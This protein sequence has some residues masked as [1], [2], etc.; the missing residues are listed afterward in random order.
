MPEIELPFFLNNIAPQRSLNLYLRSIEETTRYNR[1]RDYSVHEPAGTS[2]PACPVVRLAG[3]GD[4][5]VIA[6][7]QGLTVRPPEMDTALVAVR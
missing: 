4:T 3:L 6:K 7:L 5:E 1:A 2:S